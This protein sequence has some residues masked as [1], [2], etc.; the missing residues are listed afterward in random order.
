MD[1]MSRLFQASTKD[2]RSL[3][4]R[5]GLEVGM[6]VTSVGVDVGG[7]GKGVGVEVAAGGRVAA[8]RLGGRAVG[9]GVG[10]AQ[11]VVSRIIQIEIR[12]SHLPIIHLLFKKEGISNY[13]NNCSNHYK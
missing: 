1:W 10:G 3:V 8:V 5:F 7:G 9:A 11:A 4:C 13:Y 12:K 6:V 2:D